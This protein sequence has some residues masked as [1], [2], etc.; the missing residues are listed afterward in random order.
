[1]ITEIGTVQEIKK[2]YAVIKVQK[3]SA[4]EQ[5]SSRGTCDI[6]NKDTTVE[7]VNDLRAKEGDLVELSMPEAT[8]LKASFLVYLLPVIALLAGAFSGK[9]LADAMDINQTLASLAGAFL[10][11][12]IVFYIL[13]RRHRSEEYQNKYRPRMTRILSNPVP[14]QTQTCDSI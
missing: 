4:C 8:L 3:S 7:V 6:S 12:G 2:T 5:C 13:I 11:T 14:R 1:M 10:L 9:A